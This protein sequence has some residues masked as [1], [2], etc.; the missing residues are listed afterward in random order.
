MKRLASILVG[1]NHQTV[2]RRVHRAYVTTTNMQAANHRRHKLI[3][4]CA[5]IPRTSMHSPHPGL[6]L[7]KNEAPVGKSDTDI[8]DREAG[9]TANGFGHHLR[10]EL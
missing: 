6:R 4:G 7:H 2:T 5:E 9:F 10:A 3:H 1:D 8:V